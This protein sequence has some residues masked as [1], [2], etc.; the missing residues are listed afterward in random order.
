M[1]TAG[2][3]TT[4]RWPEKLPLSPGQTEKIPGSAAREMAPVGKKND[5]LDKTE[6]AKLKEANK[7]NI[8]LLPEPKGP[9]KCRQKWCLCCHI[10]NTK[11][12]I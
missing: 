12:V 10:V 11:D 2:V 5:G 1:R 7:T 3:Y 9:G 4:R 6:E 8:M